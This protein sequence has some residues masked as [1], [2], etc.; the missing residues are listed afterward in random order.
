MRHKMKRNIKNKVGKI[1]KVHP[2]TIQNHN[3][4]LVLLLTIVEREKDISFQL[5]ELGIYGL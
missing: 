5:N 3:K 4:E 2:S 1:Q